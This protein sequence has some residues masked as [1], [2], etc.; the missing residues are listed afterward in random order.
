MIAPQRRNS[1]SASAPPDPLLVQAGR[2]L[3]D[4]KI[5]NMS[6]A[7]LRYWLSEYT[8]SNGKPIPVATLA[9]LLGCSRQTVYNYAQRLSAEPEARQGD[10]SALIPWDV[11]PK[12][13][14]DWNLKLLRTIARIDQAR[15]LGRQPE[16]SERMLYAAE[17]LRRN[18]DGADLVIAYDPSRGFFPARRRLGVDL[19]Y[20]AVPDDKL[21]PQ[22]E[23]QQQAL[24]RAERL[25]LEQRS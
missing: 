14:N 5:E 21:D 18:L 16:G 25:R 6:A 12:H 9:Q 19:W 2:L 8:L 4:K 15:E 11:H 24:K 13:R 20:V 3:A 1:R 17:K 22:N 7:E 23:V 10:W